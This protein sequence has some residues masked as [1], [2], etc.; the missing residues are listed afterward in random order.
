MQHN[1]RAKM[2]SSQRSCLKNLTDPS[3]QAA[4]LGIIDNDFAVSL[5]HYLL[6]PSRIAKP[7]ANECATTQRAR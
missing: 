2:S 7:E 5:D 4:N 3:Q 6:K 1:L